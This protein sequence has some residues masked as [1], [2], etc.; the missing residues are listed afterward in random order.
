[1]MR[2]TLA[3]LCVL[4]WVPQSAQT[5]PFKLAPAVA[6]EAEDFTI[7]AGWKVIRNG[8]GNYMVD[9]VGFNHISGE[10]LL[11][12]DEKN[13]NASAF[14]DVS[15][16]VAGKYRLWVRYEYPAFCET[17]FRV[18]VEQGGQQAFNDVM[19]KKTSLRYAFGDPVAK[20]QHD[21]SWGPEGLMEEAATIPHL[22]AGKARIYLKGVAQPQTPGVSAHRN[23]DLIYLTS[24][25]TDA[26][27]KHY[28]R[29]TKLYPILDTFRDTRG[30]RWQVRFTNRGSKNADFYIHHVYNRIP[31]N[32]TDPV[33]VTGLGAG[34]T[35]EWVGL[36]GQD[37]AHFSMVEFKG[38]AGPFDVELRPAGGKAVTRKLSGDHVVRVYLPPYPGKGET[39]TTPEE[40]IDGILAELKKHAPPGKKPTKP[41]CYGGWM[42]LGL[43]SDYGRK[44]AQLYAAL[45]FRSLHPANSGPFQV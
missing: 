14:I 16:P 41:L 27:R 2:T 37:T 17:Q 42:P 1:M 5:Q 25:T 6:V 36:L 11:G 21:P 29:Q 7:E 32:L 35:S 10:R 39:P 31:W 45:G 20:A 19:G 4:V 24:D 43:D 26:W 30:P 8:H 33:S 3:A 34:K 44:Y 28:E 22:K 40:A 9:I 12:I 23:I 18:I 13:A 15:V 38:S